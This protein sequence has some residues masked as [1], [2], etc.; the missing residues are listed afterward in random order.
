MTVVTDATGMVVQLEQLDADWLLALAEDADVQA[1]AA[2]RAK[3]RLAAQWCVLH[4]VH[5]VDAAA[6]WSDAGRR[7][8][9]GSVPTA[10]R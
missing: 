3:L 8:R 2:E 6:A 9:I 7:W 1:R 4:E 10:L 5:D